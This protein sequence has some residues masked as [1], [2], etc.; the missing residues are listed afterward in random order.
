MIEDDRRFLMR[1]DPMERVRRMVPLRRGWVRKRTGGNVTQIHRARRGEVTEEMEFV[2]EREGLNPDLVRDEVATGRMVIPANMNHPELEPMAIGVAAKCK[3]NVNLGNSAV[4]SG[5]REELAKLKVAL[6]AGADAVMDLSTGKD[7]PE[8]RE[9]L[10]RHSPVPVGT[11]PIYEALVRAKG[12]PR[13]L[14]ID[15]M[16][17][18]IE[19]QARQGVDYMTCLLYTSP[20]PRD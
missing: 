3:I 12:D 11:V 8:I 18:V 6:L 13:D 10:L 4:T 7:I 9:A 2:A 15:L 5:H 20:S 16:L 1:T 17:K 14:S 19:E